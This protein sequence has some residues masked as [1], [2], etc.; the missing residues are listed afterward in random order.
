[1]AKFLPADVSKCTNFK[2]PLAKNCLRNLAE[3]RNDHQVFSFFEPKSQ[4]ECDYFLEPKSE[5]E[6]SG[7]EEVT[8]QK[9]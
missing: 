4:T 1:M 9:F 8:E 5:V 3:D 7:T 6:E 2:C